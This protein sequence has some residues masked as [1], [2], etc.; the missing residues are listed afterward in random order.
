MTGSWLCRWLP[1]RWR[2]VSRISWT[3][4]GYA[5]GKAN[6]ICDR[7]GLTRSVFVAPNLKVRAR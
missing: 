1:H 4:D 2:E 7:C 3:N 6:E 5:E